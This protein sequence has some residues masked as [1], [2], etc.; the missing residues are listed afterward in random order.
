MK[1]ITILSAILAGSLVIAQT[2]LN[3]DWYL[4]KMTFN[5]TEYAPQNEESI[6]R[7]TYDTGWG[8]VNTQVCMQ[9]S[10]NITNVT[11]TQYGISQYSGI[12]GTCTS[13][14]TTD[15]QT[16]YFSALQK[17]TNFIHNYVITGTGNGQILTL[18][19][20]AGDTLVFGTQKVLG[21]N[22]VAR[23]TF[24]IY[25]NPVKD[26]INI[27]GGDKPDSVT[28]YDI[29]GKVVLSEKGSQKINASSLEKGIYLMQ[30]SSGKK[31]ETIK[32]IKE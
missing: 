23:P 2:A 29:T 24:S 10:Y 22:D 16:K 17:T 31:T 28:V 21:V 8:D 12:A 11:S 3:R 25:P 9:R 26:A 20:S 14:I 30:I 32:V 15:F 7:L 4:Q 19:T 13:P 6:A 1:K 27:M 18:T 5:G